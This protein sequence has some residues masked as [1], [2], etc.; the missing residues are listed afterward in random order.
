MGAQRVEVV[1]CRTDDLRCSRDD[2]VI[3]QR[4]GR[5]WQATLPI[6][7]ALDSYG[8]ENACQ[9]IDFTQEILGGKPALTELLG[10][11]VRC[12]GNRNAAL[13]QLGEQSRDQRGVTRIVEFEL[14]DAD[15]R[16]VGQQVDALDKPEDPGQ[17]RQLTEGGERFEIGIGKPPVDRR[18]QVGLADPETAVEVETK[19]RQSFPFAEEFAPASTT[20]HGF[21]AKAAAGLQRRGL[22][23]LGRVGP[24]RVEVDIGERRRRHK[25][26]DQTLRGHRR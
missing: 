25:L 15:H 1:E 18:Q 2:L 22:G 17:L 20:A 16:V 11:G 13:H 23:G 8:G 26:G 5:R 6:V 21:V 19:P 7:R 24:V 4:F 10:Q 3:G 14:V 12:R 9:R